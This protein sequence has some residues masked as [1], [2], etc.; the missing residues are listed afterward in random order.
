[1]NRE[2]L[3]K[4]LDAL[5][6][7]PLRQEVLRNLSSSAATA[8][9]KKQNFLH[10]CIGATAA[11]P[12]FSNRI[13]QLDTYTLQERKDFLE[14]YAMAVLATLWAIGFTSGESSIL[15]PAVM[16]ELEKWRNENTAAIMAE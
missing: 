7:T 9:V 4:L 3:D 8:M 12:Y 11:M 16:A 15:V 13:P 1:M 14:K 10:M 6:D 2:I 5:G